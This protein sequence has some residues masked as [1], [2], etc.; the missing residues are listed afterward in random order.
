MADNAR[1]NK[2][3]N[4]KPEVIELQRRQPFLGGPLLNPE[5]LVVKAGRREVL[6][7]I[8][9]SGKTYRVYGDG[10]VEG[11]ESGAIVVNRIPMLLHEAQRSISSE[12]ACP[13]SG[14]VPERGGGS[15]SV[16]PIDASHDGNCTTAAGEK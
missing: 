5:S 6:K 13:M 8:E 1:F 9:P 11:F 4:T 2:A 14:E 3:E 10:R 15:H 12:S 7:I 16:A